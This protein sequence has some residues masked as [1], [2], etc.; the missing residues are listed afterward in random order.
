MVEVFKKSR[1]T[2]MYKRVFLDANIFIEMENDDRSSYEDSSKI[3]KFLLENRVT[4]YTSC[5]LITTIYYILAKKDRQKALASIEKINRFCNI[6]EFSNK[7]VESTCKLMR[8]DKNFQDLEDTMQ[9]VLALK[10]E[11]DLI[12]S[13]DK[14]FVSKDIKLISA[15]AFLMEVDNGS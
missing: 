6:I 4:I 7:E 13:N 3:F 5:D 2:G 9:Y 11:C 10:E 14:N 15:N 8:E 12:I 1:Q